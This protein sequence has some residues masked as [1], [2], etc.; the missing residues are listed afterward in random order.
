MSDEG[1]VKVSYVFPNGDKYEGEC[2]RS[3]CG[4]IVRS[5]NGKH[6]SASGVT[7]IGEWHEDKVCICCVSTHCDKTL[8]GCML[9]S[10]ALSLCLSQMHGRGTLQHPSGAV[11]EGEFK[12]NMYHGTGTYTFPDKSV[13]KGHFQENRCFNCCVVG[14]RETGPLLT[15]RAWFGPASFTGKQRWASNC[16]T[17]FRQNQLLCTALYKTF[18]A[19]H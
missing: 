12:G 16:N 3:E 8:S 10:H 6:T 9:L 18:Y 17:A 7:Y 11:Y 4:A 19:L 2:S 14:W 15:H 13:Y 5:G 1:L